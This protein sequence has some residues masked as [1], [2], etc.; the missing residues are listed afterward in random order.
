[1][2]WARPRLLQLV[3][4][5]AAAL[6][7]LAPRMAVAADTSAA[8]PEVFVLEEASSDGTGKAAPPMAAPPDLARFLGK[9]LASVEVVLDNKRWPNER[10]PTITEMRPGDLVTPSIVRK[11]MAEALASG[12]FGDARV[13]LSSDGA[14][15]HAT[16]HVAP[17]KVIDSIH[18]DTHGAPIDGDELVRDA[19]LTVD[20]ELIASDTD[21]H[22][23]VI[24]ALLRTHGYPSPVVSISTRPTADPLRVGVLVDVAVGAPRKVE[25]RVI[26]PFQ[27]TKEAVSDAEKQYAVKAG[28]R[29][30]ERAISV[31]DAALQARIRGRGF[32]RA[33]VSHD[34]VLHQGVVVLRVR[35]DFGKIYETRYE[36]NEHFDKSTLDESLDLENESDRAPSH[37]AQKLQDYYVKHGFLDAT[38][39]AET[40]GTDANKIHY[41]VFKVSEQRR[42][43]VGARAYP[44]LR[45]SDVKKLSEGGPSSA[46]AI[47]TEID[48]YLE[49]ELPGDD[50]LFSPDPKRI[51]DQIGPLA[52]KGTRTSPMEL[53]PIGVYA[54]DTYER[55]VQHVQELYRSEG[56]LAAQVGPVQ[57]LRR[58]CDP[59]SPAGQCRPLRIAER[60]TDVCTYDAAGLPLPV[61]SLE[62]GA[63]VPDPAK[64]ILC[65]S[66]VWLRIPVKLGPRTQLWDISFSGVR[67]LSQ[68]A[69]ARAAEVELGGW[70]STMKL[71]EARRRVENAYKEEGYAFVD[72]KYT[73]EQSPDRTR[74]RVRFTVAEG[75]QIFV[76][77]FVIRGNVFT[78]TSVIERRIALMRGQPYRASE[79]A[80]T[81][82]RI[83]TL[84]TFAS[85]DVELENPYIPQRNKTVV[86]TVVEHPRQYTEIKPGFSTGEGFRIATEYG[87]RNLWGDAVG[88]TLKL[89]LAYIP[90]LLIIDPTTRDNARDLE[91][92]ARLRMLASAGLTLPEIGLGPL[93]RSGI[94]GIIVH[95][96]QRDYLITKFATIPSLTW[97]PIKEFQAAIFQSFE[98][99]NVRIFGSNNLDQYL[100]ANPGFAAQLR[101]PDGESYVFAQRLLVTWDRRDVASNA[102][103]GTFFVTGVEH[104]DGFPLGSR[105]VSKERERTE[106]HFFRLSQ[107]FDAYL[108]LLRC[109]Q[110]ETTAKAKGSL[111]LAAE[112]KVGTNVQLTTTS[113]TYPDRLFFMGGVDSM[114]GWNINSFI[115][116]DDID[117]IVRD[118][119]LPD[120]VEDPANPG[121]MKP[122]ARFTGNTIQGGDLSLMERL[123]LRIPIR[124]PFE[125]VLFGDIG[126]LWRDPA[127]PFR[128]GVFPIRAAVGTGLRVQTPVGPLAFDYGWNVTRTS[129]VYED[130]GAFNFAIGLF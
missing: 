73:L 121:T 30:D 60:T 87:H 15:I 23:A 31:A 59:R 112:T 10:P 72:V 24:E 130:P 67:A 78:K 48:S 102:T 63:C 61:P 35:V 14:G 34:L 53:D 114:R 8:A 77:G 5:L 129:D 42:V 29:A 36:G 70:V 50:L 20:G 99:N 92:I 54:P 119:S 71:E 65:E 64:N 52:L 118:K 125:T 17:R 127:Y 116:Q 94:E 89:Q 21:R 126:N 106:S 128:K 18:V 56:F 16:I 122:N 84:G 111:R 32:H 101:V 110:R 47:G 69:L 57:V 97:Q 79:I 1:M 113:A 81:K 25:R 62:E 80:K 13:E 9:P 41:V 105:D 88:L 98:F 100:A 22:H 85:V 46:K 28:D 6:G 27:G 95:D 108:C 45:E 74:A 109:R 55:A 4:C 117:R 115:P 49:E 68:V 86:V 51:D 93:F 75:E 76:R 3:I 39:T 40:R 103:K 26:Y 107:R 11:A 43:F 12:H 91:F 2:M 96:L 37:L 123:E 44:C 38:V 82:E 66:R 83:A 104:V 19:D 7:F 33:E 124:G 58:R 120:F 90:T